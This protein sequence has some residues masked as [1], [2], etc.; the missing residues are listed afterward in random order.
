MKKLK[1]AA[2]VAIVALGATMVA[3]DNNTSSNTKLRNDVDSLSYA[4]GVVN[5]QGLKQYLA[6]MEVDTAYMDAFMR[7]LNDGA[8]A[9]DDKKKNAY[10][11]GVQIGQQISM[12]MI[13]GMNQDLFGEDST[14]TLSMKQ[15]L[16]GFSSA[17]SGKKGHM[18]MEQAMQ[19]YQ[20]LSQSIKKKSMEKVYG[21]Y[22]KQ[23]EDWLAQNAKKP[24]VKTLPSGVQ[25]KVLQE[26]TG[27]IPADTSEVTVSYE[28]RL[29]DGTVFDSTEKHGGEPAH[30][31]V[32][33]VIPGWTEALVHMPAGST[34]EL[35]I[36][37]SQAY[38]ERQAGEI[39][40]FSTLVFKV[41][42]VSVK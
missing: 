19:C 16:A 6:Q 18:T 22:K 4:L 20:T 1:A 30:M 3:C 7:G 9:G 10:Y 28:G 14:Q 13:K 5:T 25:Y 26:G 11:M 31:R 24:G 34:W 37:S 12:R 17:V 42:L 39:K 23:N 32:N 21:P 36:P 41:T 8:N 29:I 15:F 40:P 2:L 33:Q 27:A 38:G 35:Y